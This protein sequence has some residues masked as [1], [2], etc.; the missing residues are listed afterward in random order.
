MTLWPCSNCLPLSLDNST[1]A[2]QCD[3]WR[4]L[5]WLTILFYWLKQPLY[6]N[7]FSYLC[8]PL[9]QLLLATLSSLRQVQ[10]LP[11]LSWLPNSLEVGLF[12]QMAIFEPHWECCSVKIISYVLSAQSTQHVCMK[13]SF[14]D[15]PDMS[16][17]QC[18]VVCLSC[19]Q[20]MLKCSSVK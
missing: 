17:D 12:G 10:K 15:S 3:N 6:S 4:T 11:R 13:S 5:A 18:F 7:L 9:K 20:E 16:L 1:S 19:Q 8:V 2:C 14:K